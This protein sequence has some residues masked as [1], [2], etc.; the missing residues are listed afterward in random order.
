MLLFYACEQSDEVDRKNAE[1]EL[2][3]EISECLREFEDLSDLWK[4]DWFSMN[5]GMKSYI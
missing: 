5:V 1:R 3:R 2:Q 4:C